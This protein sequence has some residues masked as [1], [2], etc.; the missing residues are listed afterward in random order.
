MFIEIDN[1]CI[2]CKKSRMTHKIKHVKPVLNILVKCWFVK[3]VLK[4]IV[5]LIEIDIIDHINVGYVCL[6]N[7][8]NKQILS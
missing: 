2:R 7:C 3:D 1:Y 4:V 6:K 5:A 8:K